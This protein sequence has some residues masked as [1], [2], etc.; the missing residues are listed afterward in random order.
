MQTMPTDTDKNE[1]VKEAEVKEITLS[2]GSE[3]KEKTLSMPVTQ[4]ASPPVRLTNVMIASILYGRLRTIPRVMLYLGHIVPW[5]IQ[6]GT[7]HNNRR[8]LRK[9]S[10]GCICVSNLFF[11]ST[12]REVFEKV[13][14][15]ADLS[16]ASL[17]RVIDN[18]NWEKLVSRSKMSNLVSS[19]VIPFIVCC[20]YVKMIRSPPKEM[21]RI[22]NSL[23]RFQDSVCFEIQKV[24]K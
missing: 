2:S 3:T 19:P 10:D 11:P 13:E 5:Q 20:L 9:L 1:N 15:G 22:R 6:D 8:Q 17:L 16:V 24:P 23:V 14:K 18:Q 21:T 12:I 7:T 4:L